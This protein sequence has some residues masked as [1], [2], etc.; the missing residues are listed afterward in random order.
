MAEVKFPDGG[1]AAL[2]PIRAVLRKTRERLEAQSTINYSRATQ[3]A[4]IAALGVG[5]SIVIFV[6]LFFWLLWQTDKYPWQ[7][8][9]IRISVALFF[10]AFAVLMS[11][12]YHY[13]VATLQYYQDELTNCDFG[14]VAC[15]MAYHLRDGA[16]V[17]KVAEIFAKADRNARL[18]LST[19]AASIELKDFLSVVEQVVKVVH[20]KFKDSE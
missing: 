2:E 20:P 11:R 4:V 19:K 1:E 16:L 15:L 10:I 5:I 14:E 18:Q 6:A 13:S 7:Y 9:V 8:Y 12:W 17:A 3:E